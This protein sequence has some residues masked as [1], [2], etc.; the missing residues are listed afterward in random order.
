MLW[1]FASKKS[2]ALLRKKLFRFANQL[3]HV[4][5]CGEN[6]G[7]NPKL[8]ST[9]SSLSEETQRFYFKTNRSFTVIKPVIK[10]VPFFLCLCLCLCHLCYAYRA[11]VNQALRITADISWMTAAA[12]RKTRPH[13]I[14][15]SRCHGDD[16]LITLFASF[17]PL[18]NSPFGH[19]NTRPSLTT[20]MNGLVTSSSLNSA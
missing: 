3:K 20:K 4:F 10:H 16:S 15:I 8:S 13:A 9:C 6:D 12:S 18:S 2:S 1:N 17:V 5:L 14:M 7:R 19:L 11:S